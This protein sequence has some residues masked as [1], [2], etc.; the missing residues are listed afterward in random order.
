MP[1]GNDANTRMD[2][3]VT[4]MSESDWEQLNSDVFGDDGAAFTVCEPFCA[5]SSECSGGGS[6]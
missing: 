5:G 3:S 4:A 6:C 1:D 2:L